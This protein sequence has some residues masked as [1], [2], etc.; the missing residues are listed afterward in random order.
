MAAPEPRAPVL[1]ACTMPLLMKTPPVYVLLPERMS[2]P[3]P[4]FV[5]PPEPVP[6]APLSVVLP[7][8]PTVRL[9]LMP[10]IVPETVRVPA[11]L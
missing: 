9:V 2:V 6:M 1:A 10:V 8:P 7:L 11:S 4:S 3:V 5:S